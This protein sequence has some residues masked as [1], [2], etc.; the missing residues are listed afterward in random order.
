[1]ADKKIQKFRWLIRNHE[2]FGVANKDRNPP[3][4]FCT[5]TRG[6]PAEPNRPDDDVYRACSICIETGMRGTHT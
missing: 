2:F 3:F 1:M 5:T 4:P 6:A